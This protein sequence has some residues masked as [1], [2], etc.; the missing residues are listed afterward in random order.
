VL[1]ELSNGDDALRVRLGAAVGYDVNERRFAPDALIV[2]AAADEV[3]R[4]WCSLLPHQSMAV[5]VETGQRHLQSMPAAIPVTDLTAFCNRLSGNGIALGVATNDFESI[6]RE[7]LQQVDALSHFPFICGF[8]SGFGAKPEPGMILGFCEHAGL[9]PAAV[10]MVGDSAHDLDA[11]RAAGAGLLVGVL[12]GPATRADLQPMA[13]VVLDDI[14]H[15]PD[16]LN[17]GSHCVGAGN[18]VR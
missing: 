12:T 18:H 5:V 16:Y 2:K 1:A 10:A 11:G 15:L 3:N 17:I 9:E 7:Q 14:S 13:D 6:A 4:A 8:D